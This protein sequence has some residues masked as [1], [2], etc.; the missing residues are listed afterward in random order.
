M[1]RGAFLKLLFGLPFIAPLLAKSQSVSS[2]KVIIFT[3]DMLK[4]HNFGLYIINSKADVF[5]NPDYAATVAWKLGYNNHGKIP[6]NKYGIINFLF[7][8][9]NKIKA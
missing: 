8:I 1:K 6:Y 9:L 2:N 3:P 4:K 5:K 7:K